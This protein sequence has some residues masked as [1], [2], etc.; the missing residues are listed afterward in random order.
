LEWRG[1]RW[2]LRGSQGGRISDFGLAWSGVE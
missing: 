1:V 2:S